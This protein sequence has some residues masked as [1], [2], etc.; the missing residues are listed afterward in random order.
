MDQHCYLSAII[1]LMLIW[2]IL[3]LS[4]SSIRLLSCSTMTLDIEFFCAI[5]YP[6][7]IHF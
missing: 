3:A 7:V 4:I 6:P 1:D 5:Y 2:L